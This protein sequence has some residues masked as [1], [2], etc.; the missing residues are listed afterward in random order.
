MEIHGVV[1][2]LVAA[3]EQ[4]GRGP[5]VFFR[6]SDPTVLRQLDGSKW[7]ASGEIPVTVPD[8]AAY[9]LGDEADFTV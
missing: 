3:D 9:E 1:T 7:C 4:L 8:L 5:R 6:P 2:R